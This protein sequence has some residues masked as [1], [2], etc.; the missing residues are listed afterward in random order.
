MVVQ[1]VEELVAMV[2][3]VAARRLALGVGHVRHREHLV[4]R[5]AERLAVGGEHEEL[6]VDRERAREDV[7]LHDGRDEARQLGLAPR[8][9]LV[10]HQEA[11]VTGDADDAGDRLETRDRL[12]RDDSMH[13]EAASRDG[14]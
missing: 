8:L 3:A 10:V 14:S 7:A 2:V 4:E 5:R 11:A 9:L 13:S 12:R 1:K 6:L